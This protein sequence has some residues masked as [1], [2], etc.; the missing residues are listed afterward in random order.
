MGNLRKVS[1]ACDGPFS[2][3]KTPKELHPGRT[4]LPTGEDRGINSPKALRPLNGQSGIHPS[5]L[6]TQKMRTSH[7]D[8]GSKF[9]AAGMELHSSE[10]LILEND[11]LRAQDQQRWIIVSF[12][13]WQKNKK[14]K[15][16]CAFY[17]TCQGNVQ[18]VSKTSLTI[19]I[20]HNHPPNPTWTVPMR[21]FYVHVWRCSDALADSRG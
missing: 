13:R 8:T 15:E 1:R 19:S 17:K 14:P 7:L 2:T 21:A 10:H 18:Y 4:Q 20:H 6:S 9:P 3:S 11:W 5:H 16:G 12:V